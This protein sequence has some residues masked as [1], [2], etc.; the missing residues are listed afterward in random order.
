MDNESA[1][2]S[3]PYKGLIPYLEEDAP[4]FFGRDRE[5]EN[6][7]SNL[8][9]SRL[10][11]LYGPTGAGKSSVLRAGVAHRLHLLAKENLEKFGEPELAT[12]V[13]NK[14][15]GDPLL[16]LQESIR[17]SVKRVLSSESRLSEVPSSDLS[18]AI[19]EYSKAVHGD[20]LII[21]D[22]FEEYFLYHGSK[23]ETE[24]S[25]EFIRAINRPRLRVSFLISIR[26]DALAKL[27]Y[28]KGKIPELFNNYLR[29]QH[30]TSE[31]AQDAIRKP[32]KVYSDLTKAKPE[33]T[34]DDKLVDEV[35]KQVN[36]GRVFIGDTGYG[37][38]EDNLDATHVETSF[39][40][41]VMSKLWE[42]EF[43]RGSHHLRYSTLEKLGGADAIVQSHLN[44]N[45]IGFPDEEQDAAAA[46]F[47]YLVTPSG[48]KIA[49]TASDLAKSTG[50]PAARVES[51]LEKLCA[52]DTRILRSF[53][54]NKNQR[55][56]EKHYEIYHDVLASA[57]L[58]WSTWYKKDKERA[59]IERENKEKKEQELALLRAKEEAEKE[60]LK[61]DQLRARRKSRQLFVTLILSALVTAAMIFLYFN[62]EKQ[63]QRA[64]EA[65]KKAED[66]GAETQKALEIVNTLDRS[67]PFFKA[68]M[69]GHS[70]PVLS[71][72]F[73]P[74]QKLIVTASIDRNARVWEV[75][76]GK[77]VFELKGHTLGV[78]YAAFSPDGSLIA[79]AS[80]DGTA[81]IWDANT[82]RSI[83]ILEGHTDEVSAARFS[84]DGKLIVTASSD[85]TARVWDSATGQSVSVLKGHS[86]PVTYASFSPDS[87]SVVTASI[88]GTA[89][90]WNA[91]TSDYI[92]LVG[93][94]NIVNMAVFSPDGTSIVTASS[95]WDARIWRISDGRSVALKGHEGAVNSAE[96]STDGTLVVTASDDR[97]A[98]VWDVATR[99]V[100]ELK[101]H[102]EE[103]QSAR[104]SG[105]NIRV[106][107]ASMDNT[108]RVWEA[109]SGRVLFELRG[110]TDTVNNAVFSPDGKTAATASQDNTARTWDIAG[111]GGIRITKVTIDAEPDNYYG[112]CPV[113]VKITGM[114]TATGSGTIKYRFVRRNGKPGDEQTLRFETSGSKQVSTTWMFGGRGYPT[115]SGS[116]YLEITSPQLFT[117]PKD[118][119]FNVRCQLP[120]GKD[121]PPT[122]TGE[123]PPAPP[124]PS[125]QQSPE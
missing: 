124:T 103:V 71:V 101:G 40:Q 58:A 63:R 87:L 44:V 95:D 12:V 25:K 32:L 96:F 17:D 106:I 55:K 23:G 21:L 97:T 36:A 107:T 98:R 105:D 70:A 59:R 39:L 104:F 61:K 90:V 52:V 74:D 11:L 72:N 27:D 120:R 4:F 122:G 47:H 123:P 86:G 16:N 60:K 93:H 20:L 5:Q 94:N 65:A 54:T 82:G 100:I 13:F 2:R 89:R 35:C 38:V 29:I 117:S 9:G 41:L 76:T 45:I 108:A 77:L 7:I 84:P 114:I 30:L 85:G 64:V 118:A 66:Q 75:E 113:R 31:A 33:F 88:D 37:A 49:Y 125:P 42:F 46:I 10:T 18:L 14:W 110:H 53:Y 68:I 6:I 57:I 19:E 116:Y 15:S 50:L 102:P 67:V 62:G 73:S 79:T 22:Q 80:K 43:N 111:E 121:E 115:V 78:R 51:V 3:G 81:R 83:H 1:S 92:T 109:S 8:M 69:R 34:I 56:E 99:R 91:R 26:E 24:F 112:H 28:F 48:T 119:T